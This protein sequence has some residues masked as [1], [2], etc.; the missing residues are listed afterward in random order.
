MGNLFE[1]RHLVEKQNQLDRLIKEAQGRERV[2]GHFVPTPSQVTTAVL[3]NEKKKELYRLKNQLE[4][5][6]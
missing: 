1:E 4:S 3:Y 5:V 2:V 6:K